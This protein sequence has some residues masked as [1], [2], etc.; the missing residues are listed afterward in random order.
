MVLLLLCSYFL[1]GSLWLFTI[2]D[3]VSI[4][5]YLL[6]VSPL[7]LAMH[8]LRTSFRLRQTLVSDLENFDLD[9]CS[10]R[11]AEDKD[12]VHEAIVE[13]YNSTGAFTEYVRGD[14]R[15]ELLQSTARSNVPRAY[16]ALLATAPL[17]AS[18]DMFVGL[19][20]GGA[21]WRSLLSH[22]VGHT[23]GIHLLWWFLS[24]RFLVYLCN[25]PLTHASRII[26]FLQTLLLFL[27]FNVF[28][29]F[30][31]MVGF[32]SYST[33]LGAATAFSSVALFLN[34]TPG[35]SIAGWMSKLRPSGES[36]G[37]QPPSPRNKGSMES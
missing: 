18:L 31:G 34:L 3:S 17:G 23:L 11:V 35:P 19:Y 22:F 5:A 1:S 15:R 2:T 30:G 25:L 24:M 14:L 9:S 7:A 10:C 21:P 33:N 16:I 28:Y 4:L 26:N 29:F 37:S 20:R 8:A 13:W 12:F 6:A 32:L 36:T 27:A